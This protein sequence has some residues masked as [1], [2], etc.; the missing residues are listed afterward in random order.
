MRP[1]TFLHHQSCQRQARSNP[2][3]SVF[4]MPQYRLVEYPSFHGVRLEKL[5]QQHQVRRLQEDPIFHLDHLIP[6]CLG[7]NPRQVS[8][9][10]Q[11]R[12]QSRLF[13]QSL[14]RIWY[15][16]QDCHQQSKSMTLIGIHRAAGALD[17]NFS[18]LFGQNY[19]FVLF[20]PLTSPNRRRLLPA[21]H[22][23]MNHLAQNQ[24]HWYLRL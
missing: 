10:N 9:S 20:Q 8:I 15:Q 11:L 18:K 14:S 13:R 6:F 17:C 1:S 12:L 5:Q 24:V 21:Q 22:P 19:G 2:N 23:S 4:Q 3:L 16:I 7:C